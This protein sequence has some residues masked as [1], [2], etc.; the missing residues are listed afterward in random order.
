MIG[1]TH[2]TNAVVQRRDLD[3]GRARSASAC[4]PA[5][6]C[7]R[8]STGRRTSRDW[9][10]GEVVDARG[11]PRVRRPAARAASTREAHARGGAADRRP[12]IRSVAIAAVFSPL[13]R[14]ASA[15]R[16][17]IVARGDAR[18]SR[19]PARTELGRIGLLERENAALLNACLVD[20]ARDHDRGL[21]RGA[22]ATRHRG[23]AL[24]HPERR[25][26]HAGRGGARRTRSTASR[27]APT[28]SM[29]GAAFL[30]GARRG[31]SSSTSAAPPPTSAA[32]PR[33]PARGQQRRRDRRGAHALP[34]ARPA[35]RWA[36]AAAATSSTPS[37]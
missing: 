2:F 11:R 28:N 34:D 33:L 16:A 13:D 26:R 30:S 9:S 5:P 3:A 10:R 25:H 36:S 31:A 15:R 20:L 21:Q 1:T 24:P 37:R 17:A 8:S 18:M 32:A 23:A 12:G 27:P 22:R 29:R 4:P 14:A 35:A 19:S 7:R 6:R